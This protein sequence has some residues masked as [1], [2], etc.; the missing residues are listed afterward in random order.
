MSE[1]VIKPCTCQHSYQDKNYGH[2]LRVHNKGPTKIVC[3]VCAK[4]TVVGSKK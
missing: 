2:G 1:V 3:T 4:A